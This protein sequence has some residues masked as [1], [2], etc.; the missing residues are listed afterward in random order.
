[1]AKVRATAAAALVLLGGCRRQT[2]PDANYEKGSRIY[3]ELYAKELDDAYADARMD[4]AAAL[5]KLVDPRSVDAEAAKRMLSSIET[6]RA[7]LAKQRVDREKMAAEAAAS[8]AHVRAIDPRKILAEATPDAGPPADPYGPGAAIA[9]INASTG[10]C[11]VEG[12]PFREQVTGATGTVYRLA[13]TQPCQDKLPGLSG[14]VVLVSADGR[15]YR[16]TADPTLR[17]PPDASEVA[18][19]P[20]AAER[21]PAAAPDAAVVAAAAPDGGA[22]TAVRRE[23]GTPPRPAS[24]AT[25]GEADAG[26]MQ[27]Y[28]PGQP[29]PEGAADQTAQSPETDQ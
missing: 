22:A 16:R 7:A 21:A 26:E 2:G 23:A 11:L 24:P 28:I 20:D 9:D 15:I 29:L 17:P 19:A 6:G 12:E 4:D 1:V 5:L 14:Q 8:A 25:A 10:G 13:R 27:L 18:A 3:Q